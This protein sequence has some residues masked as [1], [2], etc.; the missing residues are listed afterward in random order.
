MRSERIVRFV[1]SHASVLR[2]DKNPVTSA[3]FARL[4][5]LYILCHEW[6]VYAALLRNR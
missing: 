5:M 2:I 4:L 6:P 3:L 1:F